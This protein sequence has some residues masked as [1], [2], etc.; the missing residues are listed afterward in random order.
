[1]EMI[2]YPNGIVFR[3]IER[4]QITADL[5]FAAN[6]VSESVLSAGTLEGLQTYHIQLL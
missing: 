3:I 5:S 6:M 4:I 2:E 1:M